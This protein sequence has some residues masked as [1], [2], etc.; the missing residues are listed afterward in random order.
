MAGV[1]ESFN[2]QDCS[3]PVGRVCP[4]AVTHLVD[5]EEMLGGT[6]RGAQAYKSPEAVHLYSCSKT[7]G[8][9]PSA[10]LEMKTQIPIFPSCRFKILS[11]SIIVS[12]LSF[13]L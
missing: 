4:G 5:S 13:L 7:L 3:C 11:I 12:H 1:R 10:L 6:G 2:H 8:P 9:H